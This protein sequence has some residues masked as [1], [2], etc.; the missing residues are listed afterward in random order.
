MV[1]I[2]K[3]LHYK[4]YHQRDVPWSVVVNTILTTKPKRKGKNI[5]EYKS[6][7][8]YVLCIRQRDMLKVI[9]A[10]IIRK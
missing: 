5:F 2:T 7:R 3:T 1:I 9:N 10:K 6:K 8:F 4:K